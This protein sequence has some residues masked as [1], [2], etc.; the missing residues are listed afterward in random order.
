MACITVLEKTNICQQQLKNFWA[1]QT[2]KCTQ[3]LFCHGK[4]GV[5]YTYEFKNLGLDQK[6]EVLFYKK[7]SRI[8]AALAAG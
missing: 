1:I 7:P 3:T 5:V 6:V 8:P 4:Q 2:L